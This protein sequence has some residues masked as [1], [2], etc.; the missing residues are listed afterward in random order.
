MNTILHI[1]RSQEWREAKNLGSYHADSLDNEGFI[2]CSKSTQIVKVANRFFFNQ[3]DL[4]LL[5]IDSDRVKAEIRYE[6]AEIGEVFPHIY[7]ELNVDAVYKVINFE[8]G[9]DGFFE[10]PQEVVNLE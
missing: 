10:L 6:E 1:T 9:E 5:F 2:H 8:P 4:V 7:G 3:K